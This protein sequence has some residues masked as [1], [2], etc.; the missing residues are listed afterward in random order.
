MEKLLRLPQVRELTQRS[1]TR[2]YHDMS[3]GRFPRPIRIGPRAV[4]WTTSSLE[5]WL[6]ERIA[7]QEVA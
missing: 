3:E 1:T 6:R 2:I 5:A 4:A 7:E